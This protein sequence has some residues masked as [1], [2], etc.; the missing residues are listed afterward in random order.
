MYGLTKTLTIVFAGCLL[1]LAESCNTISVHRSAPLCPPPPAPP[2]CMP[3]YTTTVVY[4]TSKMIGNVRWSIR[5]VLGANTSAN[6]WGLL[7]NGNVPMLIKGGTPSTATYWSARK[8]RPD[9]LSLTALQT[10]SEFFITD[11]ADDAIIGDASV[12]TA[13]LVNGAAVARQVVGHGI[14]TNVY[15]DGHP[16]ISADGSV[17]VFASDRPGGEGGTDLWFSVRHGQSWSAPKPVP[18]VVN[19]PCDELC[20]QFAADSVLL[21][22]S[23]GHSTVGG[24][25]LFSA[26]IDDRGDSFSVGE[27]RNMGM[28]VN[29]K[30]DELFPA[31]H[32]ANT[33]YYASDQPT[34]NMSTRKDFDVFVLT[35]VRL[36]T[37]EPPDIADTQIPD[38]AIEQKPVEAQP[39]VTIT[40][41]VVRQDTKQPVSGAEVTATSPETDVVVATSVSDTVGRYALNVPAGKPVD[42]QAQ[43]PELF[44]DKVRVEVPATHTPIQLKSGQPTDTIHIPQPLTL[45][46]TFV[47]RV[48]F[49][50]SI[51]DAPYP[52]V[53]DSNGIETQRTW[54]SE[55]DELSRNIKLAGTR[56]KR[57]VLIGHTDD[58]D[59]DANNLMLGRNRVN[60]VMDQLVSRGVDRSVLE[61][62]SAGETLLPHRK[63]GESIIL[64]R[65]RARRVELV[66]VMQ[67]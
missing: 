8:D 59:S 44:F 51:Y 50:T 48:N 10:S 18:G 31:W 9:V 33:L 39:K 42:V 28:P 15:W 61:G 6:E 43:T 60:F 12:A 56:L 63:Q 21:F 36:T 35:N 25:D 40:G 62:R 22:S 14:S 29:T 64:W 26:T 5:R 16:T 52:N 1:L 32:D 58:V 13:Q 47:L 11:V 57:L 20:P 7:V 54:Q 19:T 66:K 45:P 23:A 24:Y 30:Y 27:P 46:T 65:K 55:L 34:R 49:P 53:L 17:L 67:E 3:G 4:D 38:V 2:A 37:T 41:V